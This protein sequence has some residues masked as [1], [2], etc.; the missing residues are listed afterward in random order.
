MMA[1][2]A[3]SWYGEASRRPRTFGRRGRYTYPGCRRSCSRFA[4][5]ARASQCA[6][7]AGASA[8]HAAEMILERSAWRV[9]ARGGGGASEAEAEGEAASEVA[10][11]DAADWEEEELDE[12]ED[13]DGEDG[14]GE[15]SAAAHSRRKM[16][17]AFSGRLT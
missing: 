12:D 15:E 11:E 14:E 9:L 17:N 7:S 10:G 16:M 8:R 6:R 4:C 1:S 13:E 5:A 2:R 3:A